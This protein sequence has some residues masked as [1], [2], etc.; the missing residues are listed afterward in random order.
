MKRNNVT[1]KKSTLKPLTRTLRTLKNIDFFC[2]HTTSS[3][4]ETYINI[5]VV[6]KIFMHY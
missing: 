1:K 3:K 2:A 5:E 4:K 6:I